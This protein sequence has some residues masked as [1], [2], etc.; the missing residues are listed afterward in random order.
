MVKR[1]MYITQ[2]YP[3]AQENEQS[4]PETAS[5]GVR[6]RR[7]GFTPQERSGSNAKETTKRDCDYANHVYEKPT[8]SGGLWT[9]NDILELIKYVKKYPGGTPERWEKIANIMN[10]T[11]AEVTHMAKKVA[12]VNFVHLLRVSQHYMRCVCFI[13]LDKR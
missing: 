12:S 5:R 1:E 7:T 11:V 2:S 10:R 3:R 8:L 9:D 13:L 6:K 4:E